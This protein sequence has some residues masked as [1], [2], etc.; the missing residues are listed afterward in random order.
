[1]KKRK[2][3]Y[4][5]GK[6][7]HETYEFRS[8]VHD[9]FA[10]FLENHR[11][12]LTMETNNKLCDLRNQIVALLHSW[13]G[14]KKLESKFGIKLPLHSKP[15]SIEAF[16]HKQARSFHQKYIPCEICGESRVTH[17]CHIIPKSEGGPDHPE[18]YVYL[19]PTHHHLFDQTRLSREE[20]GE[21]DFLEKMSVAQEYA[22][23]V[24]EKQLE[25]FWKESE[26][27]ETEP[28]G[29]PDAPKTRR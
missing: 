17:Y 4:M 15:P 21:I 7:Y 14:S 11:Q 16:L 3:L 26:N 5:Y 20:W 6:M 19:C 25:L 29:A 1:M 18:N 24:R 9:L 10:N 28:R 22:R 23:E 8:A 13:I 2:R 12:E 27:P